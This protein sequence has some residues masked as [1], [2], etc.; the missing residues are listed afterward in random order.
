MQS[1]SQPLELLHA[2]TNTSFQIPPNL[3]VIHIVI[4]VPITLTSF[5][6]A[7]GSLSI[8]YQ[9]F[10]SGK[11]FNLNPLAFREVLIKK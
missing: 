1:A 2:Q 9:L 3:C 10:T 8:G 5:L 7:T 4:I 6:L 11:V